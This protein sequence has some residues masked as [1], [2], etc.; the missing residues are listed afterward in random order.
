M[1]GHN[2]KVDPAVIRVP[3]E[4]V[5]KEKATKAESPKDKKR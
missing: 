5:E 3:R 2:K 1:S 4:K